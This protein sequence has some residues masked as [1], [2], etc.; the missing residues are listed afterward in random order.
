VDARDEQDH[1]LDEPK[2]PL[3]H[4]RMQHCV[5]EKSP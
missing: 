4:R 3:A 5:H 2:G 1:R